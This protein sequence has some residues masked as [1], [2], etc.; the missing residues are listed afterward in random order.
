MAC[1]STIDGFGSA[2]GRHRFRSQG[3][4]RNRRAPAAVPPSPLSATVDVDNLI[5]TVEFNAELESTILD[6]SRWRIN[7]PDTNTATPENI[8]CSDT[9][10]AGEYVPPDVSTGDGSIEYLGG[11]SNFKGANGALIE[12]FDQPATFA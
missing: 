4:R 10:A 7:T 3:R 12:P 6:E 9:E 8:N 2:R 5:F 1:Y 11:D